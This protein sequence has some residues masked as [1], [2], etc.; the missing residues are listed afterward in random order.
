MDVRRQMTSSLQ[1]KEII[2]DM[3]GQ[4]C[5]AGELV[6]YHPVRDSIVSVTSISLQEIDARTGV[7]M[8]EIAFDG[9]LLGDSKPNAF[10][11]VVACGHK[12][13]VA[14]LSRYLVIWDLRDMVLAHVA[15]VA[16]AGTMSQKTKHLSALTASTDMEA[17]L[18]FAHE[19]SQSIKV[20]S[21]DALLNGSSTGMRKLPRKA[22]TRNSTI[23]VLA[24]HT[25]HALLGCGA[26]D[27]TVQLWRCSDASSSDGATGATAADPSTS[28]EAELVHDLVVT[29]NA[30]Q[31]PPASS[32]S[33]VHLHST[34]PDDL[35]VAV[36]YTSKH[37]DVYHL[38]GRPL[39]PSSSTDPIGS[40]ALPHGLTF[41]KRQSVWF[42]PARDTL[43]VVL[44]DLSTSRTSVL[45]LVHFGDG[46]GRFGTPLEL[47]L[48]GPSDPT[49]FVAVC[50]SAALYTSTTAAR[51]LAC[52]GFADDEPVDVVTLPAYHHQ[53]SI[54]L[55]LSF[56]QYCHPETLPDRLVQLSWTPDLNRFE[57]AVV[58]LKTNE[59]LPSSFGAVPST[60]DNHPVTPLRVLASPDLS[61]VGVLL[62]S[63]SGSVAVLV[64]SADSSVVYDVADAC[65]APSG[66]LV[67]LVPSRRSVRW[68][69][70]V[71]AA[72]PHGASF[73][74]PVAADRIFAT[75]LPMPD[76]PDMY[77]VL[78]VIHDTTH[79]TLRL[80]DHTLAFA[81]DSAMTWNA[82]K[83][84]RVLDVQ[85]EPS[86]TQGQPHNMAVLTTHRIVIL[87]PSMVS[88]ACFT[89]SNPLAMTPVSMLWIGSAIAFATGG[90][91]LYYL[92]TQKDGATSPTLLCALAKPGLDFSSIQLLACMPDR[93]VYSVRPVD[94]VVTTLTRPFSV[95]EVFALSQDDLD[96]TRQFVHREVDSAPI[97]PVSHRLI[98]DLA[99]RDPE[100]CLVALS[101]PATSSTTGSSSSFRSTSH[102]ATSVVC[103]LLLAV[104]RWK[105]AFL[106]ALVDDPGLQEYARDPVGASGAQL[107][108]RSSGTSSHLCHLGRVLE[109]FGQFGTAG[110]CY[111]VAGHDHA[112]IQ[113][114]LKSGAADALD[115]L[116][117][118]FRSS[119]SA[120]VVAA[121]TARVADNPPKSD[122]FRLL[123]TEHVPVEDR[124]SRLL[125]AATSILRDAK[126]HCNP[127]PAVECMWKYFTWRRLLPEDASDWI[128]SP[129]VHYAA[130]D[131]KLPPRCRHVAAGKLSVDTHIDDSSGVAAPSSTASIGPFLDEEDGVVAYWRFEDGANNASVADGIQ[132]V[133]T[134]KRENHLTVQHLDLVLSTA[135]VDR[136]EEAKLPPEYALRFLSPNTMHGC[137]TVEVKKGSSSLDVGVAYDEDP[138]RR[139]LTVEMWVKPAAD[140]G[141][142]TG[143]L[144]RRETPAVVLWEFGLD[145]G[146]LVFTLLGQTVKS[147]P[148]PFSAEDT[149]QHVAAVV[150]ITS[151]V[152]A[153]VRLAVGGALVVTKE[154]TITSS[155][156]TGDIMS[157]VVVGPQLTGMDMTEIRIWATPRSAQQLRDMKDTY[158]TMAE[159]KKRIKMKIHDVRTIHSRD[160]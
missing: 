46:I 97:V 54:R 116:V 71:H 160:G 33:A 14:A 95:L 42:G 135:P 143:T 150:D 93:V 138:Y 102:V 82:H 114:V 59:R 99:S 12:Y 40:I 19:G 66:H 101:P 126:L 73:P 84:E 52:L 28:G 115:V 11:C 125:P 13:I 145:G 48:L 121:L 55:P 62:Q 81:A 136:G 159:S 124:R 141:G 142:C 64:T 110:Q 83:N 119:N 47:P 106:H 31:V 147:S 140:W 123:C 139:C 107:P 86:T 108:Q 70:D 49:A 34:A 9:S 104:H 128:G 120:L 74:L 117:H 36:S 56:G 151:E 69:Q 122:P 85:M 144:M 35:H 67:T 51:S 39:R 30:K 57:V 90:G 131:F 158:L 58:S 89:P 23:T 154:V 6:V 132:F 148:V 45:H 109:R 94:G 88:V 32:V 8:G 118:A 63:T 98:A 24:Y 155:T 44:D 112:L 127:G 130:E 129:H 75:R 17:T 41:A 91:A 18:F 68:H 113:L 79:D 16:V 65:F 149:W 3:D 50:G 137:G 103:G 38:H 80:S 4:R 146:A 92:P 133:D 26:S 105:D 61:V 134:S 20:V 15:E 77:K 5:V 87:D 76:A 152:R 72:E 43:V 153:S 156:S 21:V 1:I 53:W 7:L 100:L 78:F 10:E 29:F 96:L 25:A 37:V 22:A 27:G 157:T 60:L 111:D 2:V